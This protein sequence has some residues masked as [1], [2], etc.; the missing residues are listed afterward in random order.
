MQTRKPKAQSR[1]GTKWLP[2]TKLDRDVPPRARYV[3][4]RPKQ[5]KKQRKRP[6]E[7]FCV[8]LKFAIVKA[9]IIRV[10]FTWA[11]D[12]AQSTHFLLLL[13]LLILISVHPVPS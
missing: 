2:N 3:A 5:K 13:I 11:D 10:A 6:T 12:F 4:E 7:A 1:S 8:R 9:Y